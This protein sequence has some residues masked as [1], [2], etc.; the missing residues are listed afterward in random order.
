MRAWTGVLAGLVGLSLAAP[1]AAQLPEPGARSLRLASGG[2]TQVGVW[3]MVS[4]RT[5]LG[6]EAGVGLGR[7][8]RDDE[9]RTSWELTA[10]PCPPPVHTPTP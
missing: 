10:A 3:K 9:D 4:G 8:S 2:D 7:E 5:A 6:L 1:A